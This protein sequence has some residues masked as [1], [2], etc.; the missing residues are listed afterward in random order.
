MTVVKRKEH[1]RSHSLCNLCLKPGHEPGDCRGNFSCRVCDG[2]HNTLIHSEPASHSQPAAVSGTANLVAS[3]TIGSLG[4]HKLL[5]TCEVMATGPTGKAMPVRGLMDTGADISAVTSRVAKHL[6]LEQLDTTIAVSTYGDVV[7]QSAC[8]TVALTI[9]AIH[10]KPWRAQIAAVVTEKITGNLPRQSA[11]SVRSHPCLQGIQLADPKFDVPGKND[12]LLGI[13]ILPQ[14]LQLEGPTASVGTWQTTLGGTVM[15]THE[16][17]S[18]QGS[19]QA[20]VQIVKEQ[21]VTPQMTWY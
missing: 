8:P 11:S 4:Q 17:A 19:S 21:Q 16:D 18:V 3:N 5:M 14:I 7:N 15:G 2:A 12:L 20:C 6:C 9:D 1:V 13:D 10:S